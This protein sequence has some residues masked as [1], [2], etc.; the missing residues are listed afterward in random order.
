MKPYKF[1]VLPNTAITLP[2]YEYMNTLY[3]VRQHLIFVGLQYA[4][5]VLSLVWFQ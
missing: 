4:N 5:F 2:R 3:V 1:F